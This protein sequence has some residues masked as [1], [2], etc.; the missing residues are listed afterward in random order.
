MDKKLLKQI[1][2]TNA[3]EKLE[4]NKIKIPT[5]KLEYTLWNK[6]VLTTIHNGKK[7]TVKYNY[8]T[9]EVHVDK[10]ML[11]K[12][13]LDARTYICFNNK[14]SLHHSR[15]HKRMTIFN[16]NKI[17]KHNNHNYLKIVQL[18]AEKVI[19]LHATINEE[20]I[21]QKSRKTALLKNF[22]ITFR[23]NKQKETSKYTENCIYCNNPKLKGLK[24]THFIKSNKTLDSQYQ[25]HNSTNHN[26][27]VETFYTIE[28]ITK[29]N[30]F[31]I[32]QRANRK[33]EK[34]SSKSL[35]RQALTSGKFNGHASLGT[36]KN[37]GR[38]R[39]L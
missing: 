19:Q 3:I 35:R 16:M 33:R 22:T 20:T 30:S 10:Y 9:S 14:C 15:S 29:E 27:I 28:N 37:T 1:K 34:N 17:K 25:T 32:L 12:L 24:H 36:L 8:P 13:L 39:S 31:R 5:L 18:T 26:T 23:L 4:C 11:D 38:W 21:K 7:T 6:Y 2:D